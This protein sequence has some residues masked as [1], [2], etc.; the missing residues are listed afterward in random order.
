[1]KFSKS[2][3]CDGRRHPIAAGGRRMEPFAVWMRQRAGKAND[4]CRTVDEALDGV[5]LGSGQGGRHADGE[6]QEIRRSSALAAGDGCFGRRSV[7]AVRNRP[8]SA[9]WTADDGRERAVRP[10]RVVLDDAGESEGE[11]DERGA[12]RVRG[13]NA[14]TAGAASAVTRRAVAVRTNQPSAPFVLP[15][16]DVAGPVRT[17]A[18]AQLQWLRPHRRTGMDGPQESA[19]ALQ[20]DGRWWPAAVA[21][22]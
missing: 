19:A 9:V 1:M 4:G 6:Q 14:M 21:D 11:A 15:G 8:C 22:R 10:R 18:G 13:N 12:S 16:S 3:V 5:G 2:G 7:A 20:P 17:L